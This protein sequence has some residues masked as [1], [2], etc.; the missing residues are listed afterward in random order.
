M[1]EPRLSFFVQNTSSSNTICR[2]CHWMLLVDSRIQSSFE[3]VVYCSFLRQDS[4]AGLREDA[5][6]EGYKCVNL[7]CDE[8]LIAEPGKKSCS[9]LQGMYYSFWGFHHLQVPSWFSFVRLQ[10]VTRY[11]AMHVDASVMSKRLRLLP[12]KLNWR[13]WRHPSCIHLAVSLFDWMVNLFADVFLKN[14]T[15]CFLLSIYASHVSNFSSKFLFF[16]VILASSLICTWSSH[17]YLLS[18]PLQL[19]WF[20]VSLITVAENCI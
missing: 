16:I 13:D 1:F 3:G 8:P 12:G 17:A 14:S 5:F 11:L 10:D 2:T 18:L 15:Q 6:L 19:G 7:N 4:S 20:V 9:I